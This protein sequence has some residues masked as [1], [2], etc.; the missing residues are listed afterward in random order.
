MATE[1]LRRR[2]Q[3]T[4]LAGDIA[5]SI[6]GVHRPIEMDVTGEGLVAVPRPYRGEM[7]SGIVLIADQNHHVIETV[8]DDAADGFT[9]GS[10]D[11]FA[12]A[13]EPETPVVLAAEPQPQ[14]VAN[15]ARMTTNRVSS[16]PL[17]HGA[18]FDMAFRL[19]YRPAVY[20][21]VT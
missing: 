11:D 3:I 8:V 14:N 13:A 1:R 6:L 19:A 12:V 9:D 20:I 18:R 10:A 17:G 21:P 7:G 2:R 16:R 15:E 4:Q 5:V